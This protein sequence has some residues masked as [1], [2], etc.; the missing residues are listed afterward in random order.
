MGKLARFMGIFTQIYDTILI[1]LYFLI[2]NCLFF[3]VFFAVDLELTFL[4]LYYVTSLTLAPSISALLASKNVRQKSSMSAVIGNFYRTVKKNGLIFFGLHTLLFFLIGNLYLLT[5]QGFGN[6]VLFVANLLLAL[7]VLLLIALIVKL[8]NQFQGREL[9]RQSLLAL[10][11]E[12]GKLLILFL[13]SG[14]VLIFAFQLSF[15]AM[16][17][18]FGVLIKL[19]GLSL[20]RSISYIGISNKS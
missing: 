19:W 11:K 14:G 8:S 16:L 20:E 13:V 10:P 6:Q 12:S 3:Q 7:C 17:F 9:I 1:N 4:P 15:Y 18:I 5:G 2:A